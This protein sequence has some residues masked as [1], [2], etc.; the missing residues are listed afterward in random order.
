MT[1]LI[2]W[3]R[4]QLDTD[5]RLARDL[6]GA[7][8]HIDIC[9]ESGHNF[10]DALDVDQLLAEVQSKRAILDWLDLVERYMDRDDMGWHQLSGAIDV[11]EARAILAEPYRSRPGFREEWKWTT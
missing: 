8:W 3:L 1:T 4:E 10:F 2:E 9:R 5:E 7:C 6:Y 11:D